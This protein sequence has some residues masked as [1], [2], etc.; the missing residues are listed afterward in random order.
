[1][2]AGKRE[3]IKVFGTDYATPDGTC[4]RDYIHV[5]DLAQAHILVLEYL[6]NGGKSDSFNLGNG[7][8]YSVREVI[9]MARKI[10]GK[11]IKTVD[12]E[13]RPGDPASLVGSADKLKKLLKW[14]PKYADINIIIK[15]AWNWH[16]SDNKARLIKNP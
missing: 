15:T 7:D 10:T 2:A 12:W 3:N 6:L 5:N 11:E 14:Q 8:G 16:L 9:E 13:R 4:I 1:M